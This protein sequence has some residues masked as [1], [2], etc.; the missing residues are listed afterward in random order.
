MI[1]VTIPAV[2]H[3]LL[4]NKTEARLSSFSSQSVLQ[5]ELI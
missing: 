3:M 2:Q 5:W 4:G 1:Y